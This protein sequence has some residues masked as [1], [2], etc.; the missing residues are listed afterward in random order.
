MASSE[1]FRLHEGLRQTVLNRIDASRIAELP[2]ALLTEEINRC[3]AQVADEEHIALNRV[4]QAE[5]VAVLVADIM[6]LG[7][8]VPLLADPTISDI[9]VNGPDEIYIEVGGQVSRSDLRFRDQAHAMF[10]AQR[11]G[12]AVGRRVDETNPMLDARL[13]DGS[14]VNVVFPPL[15]VNGPYISIRKFSKVVTTF[16]NM[17]DS[18]GLTPAM[19]SALAIATRS[20]LN[21]VLSGGT[22]AGKTTLLNVMAQYINPGER[23]ITIEDV[24]ELKL[25]KA[26][27]LPLETRTANVEG[28]GE[29]LAR[30]L[31]RNA[32]RMRPDRIIVS[33]CRGEE[34]F[35][36]LQAM[37][38]GHRGSM[39]TLHA[40]TA[41]D[42]LRRIEHMVQISTA[43]LPALAVRSQ[44]ASAV[45]LVV[46]L[47]R[48]R[49]GVRRITSIHEVADLEGTEVEL[50][51]LWEFHYTGED[52]HGRIINNYVSSPRATK[53]DRALEFH[54]ELAA[55]RKAL[56]ADA[57]SEVSAI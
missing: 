34:T 39:T 29:V 1:F 20:R 11:I 19:A 10:I 14:R 15:A 21:I 48:M 41:H 25:Q 49:D 8:L 47:E 17:I 9:M 18:G 32:L 52:G 44:I 27:V 30:D 24:A 35:D 6:G 51:P 46:Q 38:I 53:F 3:V 2:Q 55:F 16:E 36:M 26:H 54:G 31:V 37:N 50:R 42:A 56:E 5:L 45:D 33:E 57:I 12:A 23:V 22:G 7:P 13:E 43:N 40:N 4:H 28:D